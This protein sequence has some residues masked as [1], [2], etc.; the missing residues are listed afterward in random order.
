MLPAQLEKNFWQFGKR[1]GLDFT[2]A[3]PTAIGSKLDVQ[4][5]TA[6]ISD[7]Q[8][9]LLFYTDGDTVWNRNNLKMPNGHGLKG[10]ASS[11]Q[12][13]LILQLPNSLIKY[14]IFTTGDHG[15]GEG[16]KYST[17]D[18]TLNGGLGD[19]NTD[20]KN[21]TIV[22]EVSEKIAAVLHANCQDYWII[23]HKRNSNE[24]LAYLL[25][26]TGLNLTPV[27][28]AVGA[29]YPFDAFFGPVKA[30]HHGSKIA[31]SATLN[32][33][34]ELFDFNNVTGEITNPFNLN[35]LFDEPESI[36]GIEFSPN[37]RFLYLAVVIPGSRL[38]QYDLQTEE[39]TLL[40]SSAEFSS[41]GALQLGLD[42]KIYMARNTADGFIDV[43]HQPNK[44]GMECQYQEA[45]IQ[46]LPGTRTTLGL[47]NFAGFYFFYPDMPLLGS[48]I[49]RCGDDSM[50]LAL[51][52]PAGCDTI[53]YLWSDSSTNSSIDVYQSGQYW[54][55]VESD[56]SV[57]R[58][59]INIE[60]LSCEPLVHYDLEACRSYMSDGSLMDYTEFIPSYPHLS[61]CADVSAQHV[62]RSPSQM[63]KHSCTPG[64]NESVGMCITTA[65]SCTYNAG[66]QA[67]LVVETTII[68]H[69]DSA[70]VISGFKFFEKSP[71]NYSW[72]DGGTGPNNYPTK[73][74]IRILKSDIEIYRESDIS[75]S[76]D[77]TLQQYSFI[78]HPAF[79][80]EDTAHLRIELIPYCP[81]G[82]GAAVSVWDIDEITIL[83][84]CSSAESDS[85][86]IRGVVK[87]KEGK[88]IRGVEMQ[89]TENS[90]NSMTSRHMTKADGAY[91]FEHLSQ[92]HAYTLKAYKNDDVLNG[93]NVLDLFAMQQ[94]LL[95]ITPFTSLNQY[96]AAD[97]NRSGTVNVY[98]LVILRKLLL[99][100]YSTFPNNT[101]WR[102]GPMPQVMNGRKI[103]LF[104][105]LR[106]FEYLDQSNEEVEF[107]GIKIGVVN[108][109]AR[110]GN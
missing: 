14:Y 36:Y 83:G 65:A 55:E 10:G 110:S 63:N 71:L 44:P 42:K 46:L 7:A 58:D 2:T 31:S 37:D 9:Q 108:W 96:I 86:S 105:E 13:S 107:I 12:S 11:T 30:A 19:I 89:L 66:D 77:W 102:F 101:S 56:G 60:F 59:T 1:A 79:R 93:V 90:A 103:N 20:G 43:I 45:G 16:F 17:V 94:H 48:D 73:Y 64:V 81:I 47:P 40:N 32:N 29:F 57:F 82:N 92:G 38:Y 98:D 72:I 3:P 80:I 88:P 5:G 70:L 34:G 69:P 39:L 15:T 106:T 53:Q 74:G 84:G 75:T 23:T 78:D 28:S 52:L 4:E 61:S 27:I 85:A 76:P 62:Y 26:P 97:V 50:T 21:I 51:N 8:G 35:T 67:S 25:T 54:V 104:K 6:S 100:I 91:S 95:G 33:L 41:Y 49:T 24:F 18:M 68:P 99:G 87:T 22:E 109:D